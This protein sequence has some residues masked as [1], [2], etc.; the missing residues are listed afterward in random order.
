MASEKFIAHPPDQTACRTGT[1]NTKLL[2]QFSDSLIFLGDG[3]R[4][5][6]YVTPQG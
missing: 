1:F 5:S 3:Q 2:H 6:L 4:G